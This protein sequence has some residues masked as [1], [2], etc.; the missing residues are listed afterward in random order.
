[1]K[2][3]F[4]EYSIKAQVVVDECTNNKI[5]KLDFDELKGIMNGNL[6]IFFEPQR[7]YIFLRTGIFDY[8]KQIQGVLEEI[9]QGNSSPFSVSCDWYS[10]NL[11][12]EYEK[13]NDQLRI[14]DVN[15]QKFE[16]ITSYNL[17]KKSF[18]KF[19]KETIKDLLQFYPALKN[20]SQFK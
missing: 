14:V 13:S 4:F 20:N 11:K 5:E 6:F 3:V 16:I 8:L 2:N 1:M 7:E 12:Y 17:F 9:E 18:N 15:D 19:Y 10:N